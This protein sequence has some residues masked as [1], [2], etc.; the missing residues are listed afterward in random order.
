M[1][2]YIT[3]FWFKNEFTF[4]HLCLA[5]SSTFI[6]LFWMAPKQSK[7]ASSSSSYTNANTTTNEDVNETPNTTNDAMTAT[8]LQELE[9]FTIDDVEKIER[10]EGYIA[11]E[12]EKVNVR[13]QTLKE[14]LKVI[15][16]KK[17]EIL[18]PHNEAL[19]KEKAKV[20]AETKKA[21]TKAKNTKI[22][23]LRLRY[24]GQIY[25]IRVKG[26]GTLK[27]IRNLFAVETGMSESKVKKLKYIFNGVVMNSFARRE[28]SGEWAMVNGDLIEVSDPHSDEGNLPEP[29]E[30]D[31][32]QDNDEQDD[33]EQ[34]DDDEDES[35]RQ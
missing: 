9:K 35:D 19:L 25:H 20:R 18:K 28:V 21:S 1:E 14:Q 31:V 7:M 22:Y 16:D 10:A 11:D 2:Q 15:S 27:T 30:D 4:Y 32:E 17:A 26:R 12:K 3:L 13:L 29:D 23:N 6:N 24:N 8:V 33:N 5:F 34:D